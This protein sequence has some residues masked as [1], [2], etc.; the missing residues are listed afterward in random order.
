MDGE[1]NDGDGDNDDDNDDIN[2]EEWG[3][4]NN[5]INRKI[6]ILILIILYNK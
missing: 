6:I 3:M 5:D 1:D 4:I 2:D